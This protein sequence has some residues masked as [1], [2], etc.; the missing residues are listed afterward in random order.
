MSFIDSRLPGGIPL[1]RPGAE[2]SKSPR[3]AAEGSWYVL[4]VLLA[5]LMPATGNMF[6][7]SFAM[8]STARDWGLTPFWASVIG[9]LPTAATPVGES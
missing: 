7:F 8:L 4:L 9:F 2:E 5:S 1:T 3:D 6:L